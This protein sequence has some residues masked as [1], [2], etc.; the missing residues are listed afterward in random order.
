MKATIVAFIERPET[1]CKYVARKQSIRE[2]GVEN[3]PLVECEDY[4]AWVQRDVA[5]VSYRYLRYQH[6]SGAR[7][8]AV[9]RRSFQLLKMVSSY[10]QQYQEPAP[11]RPIDPL[12]GHDTMLA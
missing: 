2:I 4:R 8:E 1:Q 7:E 10:A 3:I 5:L 12:E 9:A 6:E 11:P